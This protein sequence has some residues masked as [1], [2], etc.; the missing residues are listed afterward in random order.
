[1]HINDR[2]FPTSL[3]GINNI[4]YCLYMNFYNDSTVIQDLINSIGMHIDCLGIDYDPITY[5]IT[6]KIKKTAMKKLHGTRFVHNAI[7]Y[8]DYISRIFSEMFIKN[9]DRIINILGSCGHQNP[10]E[11]FDNIIANNSSLA[12]LCHITCLLDNIVVIKL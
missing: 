12:N 11:E 9:K 3:S 4:R 10:I 8:Y 7:F 6:I 2:N 5:S 1:M